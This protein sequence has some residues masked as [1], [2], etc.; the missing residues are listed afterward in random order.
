MLRA[1]CD[2]FQ[3]DADDLAP[4]EAS[5]QS[6]RS[7]S[8][9]SL[10]RDQAGTD[11]GELTTLF[12]DELCRLA[13]AA[14]QHERPEHTLQTT[15]LACEAYLRLSPTHNG[16]STQYAFFA[17][18]ANTIRRMLFDHARQ[19]NTQKRIAAGFGVVL[20]SV[21]LLPKQSNINIVALEEALEL[22]SDLVREEGD[23]NAAVALRQRALDIRQQ[24]LAA[25][26]D[27]S[28]L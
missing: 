21:N 23:P 1:Q 19:R 15:S 18:A 17:A 9:E 6:P 22:R 2:H 16:G 25:D 13:H 14:L 10:P 12:Y 3:H 28:S 8:V 27:N 11:T 26:P 24:L 5:S 7:T 4:N 20:P